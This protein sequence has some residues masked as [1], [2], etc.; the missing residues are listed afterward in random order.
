MKGFNVKIK[1]KYKFL[2][3]IGGVVLLLGLSS[4]FI[5]RSLLTQKLTMEIQEKGIFMSKATGRSQC[6]LYFD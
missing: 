1:L 2:A 5:A 3:L 6:R 4:A